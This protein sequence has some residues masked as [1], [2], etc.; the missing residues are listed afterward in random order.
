MQTTVVTLAQSVLDS[1]NKLPEKDQAFAKSLCSKVI[2]YKGGSPKQEFWVEK[3]AAKIAKPE[4]D[5]VEK[6]P[7]PIKV[8]Q[9]GGVYALFK[10]AKQHLKFPKINL[11]LADGSPVQLY[12]SGPK[13]KKPNVVNVTNGAKY[14]WSNNV[15][16][17]RVLE[18]GMMET[19]KIAPAN[20]EEVKL[21]LK[22][23]AAQ[24][25]QVAA[26]YGKLTGKCCFC[27]KTL[28]DEK[29]TAAGYGPVCAKKF[30]LADKWK[31]GQNFF[32]TVAAEPEKVIKSAVAEKLAENLD[33]KLAKEA[34]A[35]HAMKTLNEVKTKN[36]E[37]DEPPPPEG[38]GEQKPPKRKGTDYLF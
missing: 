22:K 10:A 19:G 23:L 37:P 36:V 8:A 27:N 29:S 1:M 15:W 13:S 11:Q 5:A 26:E 9:F 18:D 12:L 34:G 31:E 7:E 4:G 16:Y 6:A 25:A 20:F 24:P 14:G 32:E 35:V 28:S 17:G 33:D 38:E 21:L 2:K 3:L 30:G